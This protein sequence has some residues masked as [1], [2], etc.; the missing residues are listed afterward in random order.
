MAES[1]GLPPSWA[2]TCDEQEPRWV[3]A[4]RQA[5]ADDERERKQA[6]VL[7]MFGSLI[8]LGADRADRGV[9]IRVPLG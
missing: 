3:I 5:D 6:K 7:D 4:M 2:W 9:S 8:S 1:W